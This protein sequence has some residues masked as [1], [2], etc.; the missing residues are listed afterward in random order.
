MK[1]YKKQK[2]TMPHL[3][4]LVENYEREQEKNYKPQPM[5]CRGLSGFDGWTRP[6]WPRIKMLSENT[7]ETL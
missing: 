2:L 3:K 4:Q 5:I 6:L 7:L 1:K